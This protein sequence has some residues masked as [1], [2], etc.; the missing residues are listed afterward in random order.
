MKRL[1][2]Y[3]LLWMVFLER[4]T[5]FFLEMVKHQIAQTT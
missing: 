1:Q 3:G 5:F 2:L 4:G